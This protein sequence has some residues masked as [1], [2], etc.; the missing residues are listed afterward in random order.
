MVE[1]KITFCRICEPMCGLKVQVDGTRVLSIRGNPQ[2]PFSKGWVCRKGVSF[3]EIHNDPDRL[4][5]PMRRGRGGLERI[6]WETALGEVGEK[7]RRIR[8]TYG[9]ESIGVYMGNPVAF[10]SYGMLAV[11]AFASALKTH[12]FYGAGS[13]DCNNKFAAAERVLG[14]PVL[15]PIPDLDH[16]KYLLLIGTNAV[17]SGMSIF[18]VP[19]PADS[20]RG[21]VRR[22][23]ELVVVDPRR[24]ETARLASRHLFIQPDTDCF[25]LLSLLHVMVKRDL[26][27]KHWVEQ[28]PWGYSALRELVR[29]WPPERTAPLTG[30]DAGTVVEI[31]HR[32]TGPE[33]AAVYGSIGI[34]LGRTGTLNYWLLLVVNLLSGHFDRKGGAFLSPGVVDMSRLVRLSHM[35]KKKSDE[36]PYR[37]PIGGFEPILGNYPA[38]LMAHEILKDG[39]DAM[40][41]LVVVAGNPLLS[42]PNEAH[43]EEA[44]SRL[45]LLVSLDLYENETAAFAHYLLPC[46][47]FLEREDLNLSHQGLQ[48]RRIAMYTPPVVPADGEQRE[49]WE[50]LEGLAGAMGLSLWGKQLEGLLRGMGRVPGLG[51]V[52]AGVSRDDRVVTPRLLLKTIFRMMGEVDF[53]TVESATVGVV[54]KEPVFGRLRE[55]KGKKKALR[56]RLAPPDLLQEAW[57]L[58]DALAARKTEKGEF[59]LIGKRERHTHNT[60]LH[61]SDGLLRGET[62]NYL[63][64]HPE[65]AKRKK[66]A[67][68]DEVVVQNLEGEKI[69]IP[70]RLTPDM[71]PGVVAVPHGWGH[72]YNPGW[73]RAAA[74]PGVNVNRLTPDGVRQIERFAG[75]AWLNGV[76]VKIRKAP[77]KRSRKGRTRKKKAAS[78]A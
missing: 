12:Q 17:V 30:I 45:E 2:H 4:R 68:G 13:Q 55:E 31:A 58:E 10:C 77:A 53:A 36:G 6:G 64:M 18:Q 47:D 39:P 66:I 27:D 65:D 49:E 57:R 3:A 33:P 75:M 15:H 11:P 19:R 59:L 44:F 34:N 16:V 48:L 70:C 62:T 28:D 52:L 37:S 40:R 22:G 9:P 78:S 20:L 23:G 72:R 1:E 35:G 71:K 25:F 29:Q 67:E 43:L 8:E 56:V 73:T 7:L 61:N 41:A 38:A 42:V 63:Y 76:P 74:R 60:W 32:L 21:V 69:Q 54:L 26:V 14:S 5:H 51:R 46:K 50:I 24:T